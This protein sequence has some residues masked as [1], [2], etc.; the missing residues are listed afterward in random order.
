MA[1]QWELSACFQKLEWGAPRWTE[2]NTDTLET[3]EGLVF[4]ILRRQ[5]F[6]LFF[7]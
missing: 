6:V 2:N 7:I 1:R 4:H 5:D 3:N